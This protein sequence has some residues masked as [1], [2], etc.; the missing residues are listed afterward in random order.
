[1]L[2]GD[3][4]RRSACERTD[5]REQFLVDN[6]QAV[7]VAMGAQFAG[8]NLGARIGGAGTRA[9]TATAQ[10]ADQAEVGYRNVSVEEQQVLRL[11]IEMLQLGGGKGIKR[12]GRFRQISEQLVARD[13]GQTLGA[14]RPKPAPHVAVGQRADNEEP[15][16]NHIIP[17]DRQQKRMADRQNAPERLQFLLRGA[18]TTGGQVAV[19]DLDGDEPT[20]RPLR[21]PDFA[22]AAAAEPVEKP[23]AGDWLSAGLNVEGHGPLRRRMFGAGASVLRGGAESK[24]AE[25]L[26]GR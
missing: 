2:V 19:D 16:I 24:W 10:V 20:V 15:S 4:F 17:L 5:A 18:I 6:R 11:D 25:E 7:L 1:M 22:E 12:L 9:R 21:R 13:A 23:V 14:A 26:A 8:K 3:L